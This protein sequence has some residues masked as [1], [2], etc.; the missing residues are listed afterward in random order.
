[1]A[2]YFDLNGSQATHD[3]SATTMLMTSWYDKSRVTFGDGYDLQIWH[4]GTDSYINNSTGDL[5][6]TQEADDKDIVFQCDNGSGGTETYFLLDGSKSGGDPYTIWPDN[7]HVGLGTDSDLY[8]KHDG[9]DSIISNETGDLYIRNNA[10]DKDIVFNCDDGGGGVTT[11][12]TI[13]GGRGTVNFARGIEYNVTGISNVNYTVETGDYI[14]HYA[15]LTGSGKTV[16]LN[17]DQCTEGRVLIIKDGAAGAAMYNITIA[18][19]GSETIDGAHTKV[20]NSAYGSV[21]L[22]CDHLLTDWFTI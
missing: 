3:G 2:T 4:G 7:S 11:Y 14:V 16:T 17:S 15:T 8:L 18:T 6:I 20:I 9:T 10:N 22:Y 21:T 13:D 12:M 19:E 1:M 5:V